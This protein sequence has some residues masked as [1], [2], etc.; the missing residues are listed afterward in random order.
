MKI[1]KEEALEYI[2]KRYPEQSIL[3]EDYLVPRKLVAVP[4]RG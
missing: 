2:K 4:N 1:I 3:W